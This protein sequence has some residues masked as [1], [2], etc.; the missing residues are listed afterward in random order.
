MVNSRHR[1]RRSSIK[2]PRETKR[3][4]YPVTTRALRYRKRVLAAV[5]RES[6]CGPE[7]TKKK[8]R[9]GNRSWLGSNPHDQFPEPPFNIWKIACH[10][11]IWDFFNHD[12]SSAT[13]PARKLTDPN[14]LPPFPLTPA[15]VLR[16]L[17]AG[18]VSPKGTPI[19]PARRAAW[20]SLEFEGYPMDSK[21]PKIG[22][23]GGGGSKK[24]PGLV[25]GL[26]DRPLVAGLNAGIPLSPQT[27]SFRRRQIG[28]DRCLAAAHC[29]LQRRLGIFD[30]RYKLS[31]AYS[32][33]MPILAIPQRLSEYHPRRRRLCP[34]SGGTGF[35]IASGSRH[36]SGAP[37]WDG[38][39]A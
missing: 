35:S 8:V 26:T 17:E 15:R 34:S 16:H 30:L 11:R 7:L 18:I 1:R 37:H 9:L 33:P 6:N 5:A 32:G 14:R 20:D 23:G 13:A 29:E 22:G 19:D 24:F 27:N 31:T 38:N 3:R 25:A 2:I 36:L 39:G 4:G 10:V 28:V 12:P 21:A